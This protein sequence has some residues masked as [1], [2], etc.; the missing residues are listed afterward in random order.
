[1]EKP[2]FMEWVFGREKWAEM[3]KRDAA[4]ARLE[5]FLARIEDAGSRADT[6]AAD[7]RLVDERD[8]QARAKSACE[9]IYEVI[10]TLDDIG[11]DLRHEFMPE[12]LAEDIQA[13]AHRPEDK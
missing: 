2:S 4:K 3:Q 13:E 11:F 1:M 6:L 10:D 9:L 8:V 5:A 7:L 12:E